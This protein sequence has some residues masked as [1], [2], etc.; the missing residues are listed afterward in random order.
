M[1]AVVDLNKVMVFLTESLQA[2]GV[3]VVTSKRV[4]Q[5]FE[6]ALKSHADSLGPRIKEPETTQGLTPKAQEIYRGMFKRIRREHPYAE[7][8][9]S[10]NELVQLL[11][12]NKMTLRS[13]IT[14]LETQGYLAR[15][16]GG[17]RSGDRRNAATLYKFLTEEERQAMLGL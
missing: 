8:S 13:A 10:L 4:Q 6:L 9:I 5:R 7:F 12:V 3:G 17:P 14:Q 1:E 2:E 11:K 16:P 15:V